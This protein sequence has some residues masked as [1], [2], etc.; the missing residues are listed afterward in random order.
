MVISNL[1]IEGIPILPPKADTP[2]FVDTNTMLPRAITRQLFQVVGWWYSQI[3]Q[4]PCRIQDFQLYPGSPLDI[5]GQ[6][7]RMMSLKKPFC[8]S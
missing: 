7:W 2:L 3:L 1:H 8:F 4:T 5:V 6:S